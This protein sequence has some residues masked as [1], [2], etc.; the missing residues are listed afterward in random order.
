MSDVPR[1]QFVPS[2]SIWNAYADQPQAIGHRQTISQPTV[3]AIMTEALEL[4]G[5]ET[6]LEIGTG[7]GYQAAVL[8][9]LSRQVYSIEIVRPLGEVARRRLADLGYSNVEVKIGDGYKGWPEHAP[10]DRIILTAAPPEI[11][12]ALS[13]QLREGGILV[14]P[15]GTTEQRLVRWTKQGGKL[16]KADLGAVRFVP[17]VPAGPGAFAI[18]SF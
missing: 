12:Q 1:H 9:K 13:D 10:F 17:M 3:V 7:S 6:V 2:V 18:A 16:Q 4:S 14:A 5:T 11:P 15:V 8:A